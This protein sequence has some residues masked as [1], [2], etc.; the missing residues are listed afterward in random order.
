MINKIILFFLIN[1]TC[2]C[3]VQDPIKTNKE[4]EYLPDFTL[5]LDS[6][7][8]FNSRQVSTGKR[9]V[10]LSFRTNCPY[11]RAEI[12]EILDDIDNLN[13]YRFYFISSDTMPEIKKFIKQYN[14]S[15]YST[16][17]TGQDNEH[18]FT[19]YFKSPGVPF[20]AI[21][22]EEKRLIAAFFGEIGIKEIKK[23]SNKSP[24]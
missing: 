16:I 13:D 2:A 10:L 8:T 11:C 19:K 9:I 5:Q 17:L 24:K 6:T 4:G 3:N 23:Y 18:F 1:I 7:R 15:G 14:L 22:N 20:T 12:E 21:Y